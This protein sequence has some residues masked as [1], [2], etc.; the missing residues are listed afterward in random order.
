LWTQDVTWPNSTV[1][2][3]CQKLQNVTF[4]NPCSNWQV[5]WYSMKHK[6]NFPLLHPITQ[7]LSQVKCPSYIKRLIENSLP[8]IHTTQLCWCRNLHS[9]FNYFKN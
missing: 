4:W 5:L 9:W 7:V 3:L 2:N 1:V 8:N 6:L